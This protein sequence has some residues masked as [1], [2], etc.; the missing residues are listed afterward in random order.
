V[1]ALPMRIAGLGRAL[2][3][4][5]VSS[6]ELEARLGLP[7][8]WALQKS[9]VEW[10]HRAVDETA[11]ELAAAAAREALADAGLRADQLGALINASATAEQL[12][13]DGAPR[14]LGALGA[15]GVPGFSVHATCLSFLVALDLAAQRIAAGR[16]PV[17]VVSSEVV[18]ACLDPG[19]PETSTLFGDA[20]AAAVCVHAGDTASAWTRFLH[21]TFPAGHDHTQVAGFGSA[22]HPNAPTTQPTDH[23]FQMDG[24]GAFK[25]VHAQ[26][27]PFLEALRPGL[28]K[29]LA[30]V[31]RVIPH[32]SSLLGMRS[33]RTLGWPP[34]AVEDTLAELG[35]TVAASIPTALYAA[36]RGGRVRRGDELLLVGSGAGVSLAG[37]LMR[38]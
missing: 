24:W 25:L 12:I 34:E 21:R 5:R 26:L 20:A 6:A 8:G 23:Y 13:P 35:N 4:R 22:R 15:E 2:P 17:L 28:S 14:I 36:A 7:A 9:G 19:D 16:G 1:N 10:R 27:A 32:Q 18:G 31:D 29:G 38:F 3:A 33:L 37:A 11:T 30:G